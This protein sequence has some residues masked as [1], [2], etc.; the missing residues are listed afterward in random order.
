MDDALRRFHTFKDVFLLEPA[1]KKFKGQSQW[2]DNR[3][4]EEAKGRWHNKYWNLDDIQ[5]VARNECLAGL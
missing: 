3:A 4:W 2:P 1:G 5:E